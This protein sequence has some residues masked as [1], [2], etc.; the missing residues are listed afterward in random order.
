MKKRLI[1]NIALI[2][3]SCGSL[4]WGQAYPTGN[5]NVLDASPQIGT[6]G[7]NSPVQSFRPNLTGGFGNLYITGNVTAGRQFRGFVPYSDPTQFHAPLGSNA[8]RSFEG[9]APN[10]SRIERG[11]QSGQGVPYYFRSSTL[12]P[13]SAQTQGLALPGTSAPRYQT[14]AQSESYGLKATLSPQTR[15]GFNLPQNLKPA[16]ILIPSVLSSENAQ[17]QMGYTEPMVPSA[18]ERPIP[19]EKPQEQAP[20]ETVVLPQQMIEQPQS[21][22]ELEKEAPKDYSAWLSLQAEKAEKPQIIVGPQDE[23]AEIAKRLVVEGK[24][25]TTQKALPPQPG[26]GKSK[27]LSGGKTPVVSELT[28]HGKDPFSH[29]MR[30]AQKLILQGRYYDAYQQYSEALSLKA[31]DPLAVFGQAN[32]LIGAGEL[33]SAAGYL[34]QGMNKFPK[35]IRLQIEG[36]RLLG[37]RSILERRKEQ[38]ETLVEK[39]ND[40]ELNLLLGYLELLSGDRQRGLQRISESGLVP[41]Q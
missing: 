20:P 32:A 41:I 36:S 10:I 35:F 7:Y 1:S 8:L 26:E 34:E 40:R 13:L 5:G 27:K 19:R 39:S 25:S 24:Y 28:G 17:R 12:L 18:V 31:G 11:Y 6:G 16:D 30:T 29:S 3:M 21:P 22:E 33:R 37:G 15:E 38:L 2:V 14:Q 9:D 4:C 23:F